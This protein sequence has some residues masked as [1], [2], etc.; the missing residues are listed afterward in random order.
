MRDSHI[1]WELGKRGMASGHRILAI[2]DSA[3]TVCN[4]VNPA[5]TRRPAFVKERPFGPFDIV[6]NTISTNTFLASIRVGGYS[7][8]FVGGKTT[9][10]KIEYCRVN[11]RMTHFS[12]KI[13]FWPNSTTN[14]ISPHSKHGTRTDFGISKI[15]GEGQG[16][17][18]IADEGTGVGL[19]VVWWREYETTQ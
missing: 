1:F 15:R 4:K 3:E 14:M 12:E 8:I 7:S 16:T 10:W 2:V 17:I 6:R 11:A 19:S 5:N 18:L 13:S 9:K